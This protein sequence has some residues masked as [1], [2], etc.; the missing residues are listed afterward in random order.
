MKDS[1]TVSTKIG[2]NYLLHLLM[3]ANDPQQPP[4]TS[5]DRKLPLMTPNDLKTK[6]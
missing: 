2:K 4:M 1:Y 5:N 3:P 6:T